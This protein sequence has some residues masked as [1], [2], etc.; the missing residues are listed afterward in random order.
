MSASGRKAV[1]AM[2]EAVLKQLKT[3]KGFVT[4]KALFHTLKSADK[5]CQREV[6]DEAIN[7]LSKKESIA[8]SGDRIRFQTEA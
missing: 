2:C 1:E 4:S 5:T 7:E 6:F 8:R 3:A